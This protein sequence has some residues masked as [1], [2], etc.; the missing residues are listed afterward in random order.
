MAK[1]VVK[2]KTRDASVT[3]AAAITTAAKRGALLLD[4]LVG[5]EKWSKR[6]K[7]ESLSMSSSELCVLGQVHGDF[8]QGL[9]D[10]AG[11]AIR[12]A[13]KAT[14]LGGIKLEDNNT[15]LSLFDRDVCADVDS[16]YYGFTLPDRALEAQSVNEYW[17]QLGTAWSREITKR[18]PIASLRIPAKKPSSFSLRADTSARS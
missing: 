5:K 18:Q 2:K 14:S 15:L 16:V 9:N 4:N 7:K 17:E 11:E 12:T 8:C 10:L 1:K 13:L 3:L 6:V